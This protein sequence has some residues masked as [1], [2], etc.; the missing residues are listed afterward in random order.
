MPPG[1]SR[2]DKRGPHSPEAGVVC[3]DKPASPMKLMKILIGATMLGCAMSAVAAAP[4][5]HFSMADFYRIEKIDAHMHLHSDNSDFLR[6]ARKHRFRV[7]TINVDYPDFPPIEEQQRTALELLRKHPG[8]IAFAAT[9]PVEGSDNATWVQATL[10]RIDGAIGQG[11]V[12]VKVWKNVGMELRA[13]DGSMVMIDDPRFKPVFDHLADAKITLMGHQ[14]EPRNC[15]LPLEQMSVNNDREYFQNH[16]Q[17]HMYLHPD[18]PSYEQQM[19]ARDRM[20]TLHPRLQ[21]VGVHLASLEWDVDQLGSF[22]DRFPTAM[23]DV[24]ARIGQLQHQ[25]LTKRDKVREFFIRYQDRVMYGS[26]LTQASDQGKGEFEHEAHTVWLKDWRFFNTAETMTVP[27]L[28]QPVRGL[29]LPKSIVEKLYRRNAQALFPTAWGG[30][31][32]RQA[33]PRAA[34]GV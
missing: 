19:Q 14:G 7:L 26:D 11:A 9:F 1:P 34:G 24:A 25:A 27:E 10:K 28:D 13:A 31:A 18:L 30:G 29:A 15:W 2:R 17:Y 16:P 5:D 4:A 32:K 33:K 8:D 3:V 12:A 20:L 22:L 6:H 21:F 23:I